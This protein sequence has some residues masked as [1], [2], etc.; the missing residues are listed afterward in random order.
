MNVGNITF[1]C[2]TD[3]AALAAFWSQVVE[4]PVVDGANADL[5]VIG[6]PGA[7]PNL[8]FIRVPEGKTAK[9]R[10]HVDLDADG[11]LDEV[12]A[13]MESFG[14]TFVHHKSEFGISWMTFT[15][16]EGNEFCVGEH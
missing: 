4:R 12:R 1:D 10:C 5:A 14:A 2:S 7:T 13:R 6:G 9:N 3:A 16:P 11:P 15:D 8:L